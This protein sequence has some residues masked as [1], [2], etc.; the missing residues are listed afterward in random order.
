MWH[1]ACAC[2]PRG[3]HRA[4]DAVRVRGRRRGRGAR[5]SR[6]TSTPGARPRRAARPASRRPARRQLHGQR[7][8]DHAGGRIRGEAAT[9]AAGATTTVLLN[10]FAW[11]APAP[12]LS[13]QAQ[14][15]VGDGPSPVL[16]LHNPGT[17]AAAVNVGDTVVQV[18][19]GVSVAVPVTGGETLELSGFEALYASV[20]FGRWRAAG[21]LPGGPPGAVSTPVV[22]YP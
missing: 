21:R 6:S 7:D 20:T 14:L 10:D 9:A 18:P 3:G 2:S 8:R 11:F 17:A 16:H 13:G 5:R 12:L 22:V 1:R 19:P 4:G 15:T